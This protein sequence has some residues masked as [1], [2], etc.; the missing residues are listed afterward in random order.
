MQRPFALLLFAALCTS[1]L[2]AEKKILLHEKAQPLPSK[3]LGPFVKLGSGQVLAVGDREVYVSADEGRTWT[4]R[5]LFKDGKQFA[6]RP[7]RCVLRT[8]EGT[9]LIAFMNQAEQVFHWDQAQGGPQAD[10][11]LPVYVVRSLDDGQTW[12]EPQLVQQGFCGA[13]RGMI[14]LRSG[15]IILPCQYAVAHPGRHVTVTYASDDQG[16]TW[17]KSNVIDLGEYGQYGDHGGGIEA[18][19]VELRD[20]RVWMLIRTYRGCFTEA[21]SYDRGLSW[22]DVRPSTIAASGSPGLLVRLQS[23]RIA[24]FWNRY[25]DPVRRT[26]RR[27]QLSL[28]F[29]DDEGKTWTKPVVVG[30]DPMQP[31]DKEPQHRLSYPYVYEHVP[32]QLWVT[33]MQGPLRVRLQ[34]DDLVPPRLSAKTYR[35]P[36]LADT[37]ITL[38]GRADEPAWRQAPVERDF[39]FPWKSVPTPATEFRALC[40]A[41]AFWFHYRVHDDDLVV[42]DRWTDELDAIFEDRVEMS[43]ARDD[44]LRDY[45]WW[46]IDSRGRVFDYRAAYYRQLTPAWRLEGLTVKAASLAHGYQI[47][48]RIP[49]A[50][51]ARLG[52]TLA[53]GKRVRFALFRA[54][55]SHDRSGRP[56]SAVQTLHNLGRHHEGPPPLEEWISWV[57]P[58]T[59]E[60]DFHVPAAFGWLQIVTPSP[61]DASGAK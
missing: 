45:Y 54:E 27:E 36:W 59:T 46:E 21:Y 3:L 58:G 8:R 6:C 56:V 13:L 35:A 53:P 12:Q 31:G 14:Q 44:R 11:R 50:T 49:L 20:G 57:D 40:D 28:A 17:T 47:E 18:T 60:P 15:R 22:K 5:P 4:R 30:H 2:A 52:F 1:L 55:Y 9:V 61:A 19:A 34:E 41:Q 51:L 38:D 48:G 7:E 26:G 33:T 37:Q 43:F 42:L 23:G 25:I 16:R 29:S 24:L 39:A 32:G 10:C